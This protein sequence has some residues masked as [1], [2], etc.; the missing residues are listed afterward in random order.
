MMFFAPLD[1]YPPA[2]M[3]KVPHFVAIVI[4]F[5][6]VGGCLF[7]SRNM[8]WENVMKLVKSLA[9]IITVFELIKI[10]YNFYFGYT[11]LD[12]WFPL[13]YCSL[14]IYALWFS[15]YGKGHIKR[16]GDSYMI[17]G[18]LLGGVGF[19]LLPTT[20]LMR[21]PIWHYLCIYSLFFHMMMIYVG[22][23]Y[24]KHY[25]IHRLMYLYFSVYF[26]VAA[27][28]SIG[29]NVA[30]DSNIM[31]LRDP[32]NVP[33]AFIHEIKAYNQVAYT[34]LAMIAYLVA[35]AIFSIVVSKYL[36]SKSSQV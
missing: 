29:L 4:C 19:L 27:G 36:K 30:F 21:Y 17:V 10:S 13:S 15:G 14:F 22:I 33:F 34:M 11:W 23:M 16:L 25:K 32:F 5:T 18:A 12:A 2:G 3:F 6:I 35:P 20:S 28:I 8:S 26:L 1:Q 24:L 9:I 7:L 31:I